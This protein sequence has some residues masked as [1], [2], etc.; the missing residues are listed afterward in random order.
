MALSDYAH[1][2]E[3]ALAIWWLEEGKHEANSGFP[4][5]YDEEYEDDPDYGEEEEEDESEDESR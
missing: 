5:Y 3:E 1:H 2:N 4:D